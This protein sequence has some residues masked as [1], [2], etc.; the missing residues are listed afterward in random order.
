MA[1]FFPALIVAFIVV[2][3]VT[4]ATVTLTGFSGLLSFIASPEKI[5]H[6]SVADLY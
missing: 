1:G 6:L 2:F 4:S 5:R 3:V